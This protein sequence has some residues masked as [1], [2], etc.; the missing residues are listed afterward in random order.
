MY[1]KESKSMQ[2]SLNHFNQKFESETQ[3]Q[4]SFNYNK[5]HFTSLKIV[6]FVNC[7]DLNVTEKYNQLK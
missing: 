4:A 5:L 3:F 2:F 7:C 6:S 1:Q